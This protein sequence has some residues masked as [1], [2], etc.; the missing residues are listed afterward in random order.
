MTDWETIAAAI[1]AATNQPFRLN[2]HTA[3]G[4]GWISQTYHID[5]QD[6]RRYFVKLNS[7]DKLA[8][9]SAEVAGLSEIA[10]TQTIRVPQPITHGVAGKQSFLVLEHL[11]LTSHGDAPLLGKQLAALHRVRSAQFGFA[12]NNFIGKTPQQ[13]NRSDDWMDFWRERRLKFQLQLASE[14]GYG[15]QLN[16]LGTKL[17]DALPALFAGYSPQPSLLH[18]DLWGGNH[19]YLPDGTPA[20][21]DPAVYYGDRECDLAMMELFGGYSADV[22]TA[23]RAAFPLHQG[24]A[25]RRDLYNLYHILNHANIFGGGYV[26]QAEGMM[27]RLLAKVR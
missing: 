9:F 2:N 26:R 15:D 13:N 19:A 25:L 1:D 20:I 6:G 7:A 22:Y 4:G 21:F 8:M 27:R 23:Y 14:N 24:Y 10:A 3:V 18:G 17:L 5:G 12:Q 11:E 16:D